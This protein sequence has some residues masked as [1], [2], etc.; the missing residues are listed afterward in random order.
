MFET[1]SRLAKGI[2]AVVG[3][4]CEVIIHDFHD[5]EHTVVAVAGDLTGRK[6]GA[7]IPDIHF[8]REAMEENAPDQLN[9]R[10]VIGDHTIQSSTIWIKDPHN[11]TI[12]AVCINVNF[13]DLVAVRNLI[14]KLLTTIHSEPAVTV[15]NTFARDID[16]LIE[17]TV[18]KFL[19]DESI[20]SI[21]DLCT[22]DK[23]RM[24]HALET[25]GLFRIRGAVQKIARLLNVSR[26]SIYNYRSEANVLNGNPQRRKGD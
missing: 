1:L 24:V 14:D 13:A 2:A 3:P 6:P 16:E 8:L 15:S 10:V 7:P 4:T 22:E 26:A 25:M 20:A 11:N 18:N 12:G 23:L 17:F 5:I 9:Y 19:H 21:D